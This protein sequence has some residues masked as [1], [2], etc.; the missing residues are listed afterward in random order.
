MLHNETSVAQFRFDID[1]A[2][3]EL[4]EVDI[5]DDFPILIKLVKT[6][7]SVFNRWHHGLHA[8]AAAST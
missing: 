2:E 3:Y 4:S 7:V 6:K 1:T 8:R 5:I